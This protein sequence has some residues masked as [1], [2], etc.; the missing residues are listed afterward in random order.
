VDVALLP[1]WY[2]L[3]QKPRAFVDAAIHPGR[4]LAMHI[5]PPDAADVAQRLRAAGITALVQGGQTVS[6]QR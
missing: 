6:L 4:V 3:D 5:P 1:F 2:V